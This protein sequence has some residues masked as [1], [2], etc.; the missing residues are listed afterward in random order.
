ME[1]KAIH[2]IATHHELEMGAFELVSA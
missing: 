2:G 1:F